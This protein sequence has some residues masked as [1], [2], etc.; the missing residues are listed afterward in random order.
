[1]FDGQCRICTRITN[2]LGQWDSKHD[3]LEIIPSQ[4]PGIKERFPSIPESAY[5][6]S[7]QLIGPDGS[8]WQG[9][10]AIEQLLAVLPRGRWIGWVFKVRFV[11][12]AAEK[13]YR[14]FA[15]H[16]YRLGCVDHCA[17]PTTNASV[18]K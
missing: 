13:F 14:W 17:L 7:L 4:A 9:A 11:R 3:V 8:T 15:R 16:R 2:V 18:R 12:V 5:A 1:M 10:A 6:D